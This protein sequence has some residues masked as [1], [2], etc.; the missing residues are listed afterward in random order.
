MLTVKIQHPIP[1]RLLLAL[2]ALAVLRTEGNLS[3]VVINL[4]TAH[5]MPGHLDPSNRAL[6]VDTLP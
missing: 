3:K 6:Q 2:E 1:P 4:A 5:H